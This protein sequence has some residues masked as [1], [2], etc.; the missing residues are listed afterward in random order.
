MTTQCVSYEMHQLMK[1]H[2]AWQMHNP[3]CGDEHERHAA[4]GLTFL[5]YSTR[6]KRYIYHVYDKR[7][8]TIAKLKYGI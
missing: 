7:L 4:A 6:K 2:R 3:Q 5:G 8:Y 1:W